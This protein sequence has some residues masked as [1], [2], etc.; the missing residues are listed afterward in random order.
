MINH[1]TGFLSKCV[2]A[3]K[4]DN[5]LGTSSSMKQITLRPSASIFSVTNDE[6]RGDYPLRGGASVAQR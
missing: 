6:F 5:H 3:F 2:L 1:I 4:R